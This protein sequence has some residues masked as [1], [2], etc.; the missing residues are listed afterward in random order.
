MYLIHI[1]ILR[2]KRY[3]KSNRGDDSVPES[4]EESSCTSIIRGYIL[5]RV[6]TW[7]T[8]GYS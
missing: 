2:K 7:Q 5:N 1:D 3:Y 6:F 4:L 8:G